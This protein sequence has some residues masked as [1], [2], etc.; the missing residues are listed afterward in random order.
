MDAEMHPGMP[1]KV[2]R[3]TDGI[4]KHTG[5]VLKQRIRK[6]GL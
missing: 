5:K 1:E 2:V 6:K 3:F 4:N